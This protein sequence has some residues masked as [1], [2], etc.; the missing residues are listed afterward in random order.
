MPTQLNSPSTE[1]PDFVHFKQPLAQRAQYPRIYLNLCRVPKKDL[2]YIPSLR[3][4]GLFGTLGR[5]F[6]QKKSAVKPWNL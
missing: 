6:P 4:T 3:D 5:Y 1:E 2:R